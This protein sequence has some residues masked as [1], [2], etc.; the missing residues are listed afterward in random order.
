MSDDAMDFITGGWSSLNQTPQDVAQANAE[1]A[2]A[3]SME[4]YRVDKM[5]FDLFYSNATGREVLDFLRQQTI[6]QPCFFPSA[7]PLGGGQFVTLSAGEQGLIRE[8]QNSIVR[9][10]EFRVGRAMQGPPLR[11]AAPQ[12]EEGKITN[13]KRKTT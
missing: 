13:R 6:E 1:A 7:H 5:F 9:E 8:G 11:E 12:A 2:E 10:I 3:Q 4:Q